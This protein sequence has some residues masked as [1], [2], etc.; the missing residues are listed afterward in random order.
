MT[1]SARRCSLC[2]WSSS[3]GLGFASVP[4]YDWFCRVTGFG[5]TPNV[6]AGSDTVLDQTIKIRFDASR[7]RDMP[8]EFTPM[9]REMEVRIGEN[10]PCLLRGLQP[11]RPPV[12][13]TASYNVAPFE[14]GG[15]FVKIDCF[16][17]EMQVLQPGER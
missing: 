3:W 7:A 12:A 13:G 1:G 14:A 5:G 15:F 9:Q 4:L 10:R 16:C 8:W 17:F 6:A 2:R 11:H